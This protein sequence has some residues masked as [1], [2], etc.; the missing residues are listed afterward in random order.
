MS[1][2]KA[3][4]ESDKPA[5]KP[6]PAQTSL[7]T[8]FKSASGQESSSSEAGTK[9]KPREYLY[10]GILPHME[11]MSIVNQKLRTVVGITRSFGNF[12]MRRQVN[13]ALMIA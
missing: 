5:K 4:R 1:K 13:F 7:F 11:Y 6:V 8:Y 10:L 2:R 9:K 3:D 12:G